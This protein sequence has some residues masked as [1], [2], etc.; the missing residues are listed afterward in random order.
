M[1]H[2]FLAEASKVKC[3]FT[4]QYMTQPSIE[5]ELPPEYKEF[6]DIFSEEEANK[7]APRG[8]QDHAIEIVGEPPYSP[9][10]NLLEKELKTL[11]EYLA[12]ALDRGWIRESSS[13]AGALILFVPKKGGEL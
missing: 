3:I 5:P 10:Y 13:P 12:K 7:L 2:T 6:R 9:I 4:I 11:W 1:V 8:R